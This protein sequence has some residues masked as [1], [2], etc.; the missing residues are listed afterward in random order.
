MIVELLCS[1]YKPQILQKYIWN[2]LPS[3]YFK[4]LITTSIYF[5]IRKL[6]YIKNKTKSYCFLGS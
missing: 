2:I 5:L 4:N 6:D 3:Q 1:S